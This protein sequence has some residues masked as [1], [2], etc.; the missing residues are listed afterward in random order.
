MY[1]SWCKAHIAPHEPAFLRTH[2]GRRALA[3][4]RSVFQQF[5]VLRRY[6]QQGDGGTRRPSTTLFPLLQRAL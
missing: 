3:L 1:T 6:S 5:R 4:T 2:K